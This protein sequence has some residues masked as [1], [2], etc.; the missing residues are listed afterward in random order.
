MVSNPTGYGMRRFV[1]ALVLL[2]AFGALPL[3]AQQGLPDRFS[4]WTASTPSVKG[5]PVVADK[6]TAEAAAVLTEAGVVEQ[7]TRDYTSG[8]RSLTV[9]RYST[10]DPS[11][12]YSLFTYLRPTNAADA[13]LAQAA[14]ISR[15][16]ALLFVGNAVVEVRSL[17]AAAV[18]DLRAL[19]SAL[20]GTAG[21]PS[22]PPIC[23]YLPLRGKVAGT[24]RYVLG[25][26]G[27]R[28]A[29]AY[30]EIGLADFSDLLGPDNGAEA[31]TARYRVK[32]R[33]LTLVLVEFPTPQ[34]AEAQLR[35][36]NSL[37]DARGPLRG[38]VA[39]RN[40]SLLSVVLQPKSV[41]EADTLLDAVRYET[42]VTWNEPAH[43]LTDPSWGVIIVG[44]ILS[45]G[46]LMVYAF[47]G[48]LGY[49][50]IRVVTKRFFPGKVFD[51]TSQ[52]EILQLGLSSKPIQWKDL[53]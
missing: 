30:S 26:A 20:G 27:L 36:V 3:Q 4:G 18:T 12:A 31:V 10:H 42:E 21:Q 43:K 1:H 2:A 6:P 19:A 51:R 47:L 38:V 33:V 44:T 15:N 34:L 53:Y 48:G 23:A 52:L 29:A 13:D 9:T 32:N 17:Q 28:A 11:G 50:V 22:L 37:A 39:R 46:A 14:A 25:P 41:Q 40:S 35:K 24:E 45:T 49:G 7:T 16:Q 8:S 5:A